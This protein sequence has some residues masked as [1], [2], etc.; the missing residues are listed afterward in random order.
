MENLQKNHYDLLQIERDANADTIK[1][2]F[3]KAALEHHPDK[4]GTHQMFQIIKEAYD[5]LSDPISK[6][7][8]DSDLSKPAFKKS[9]TKKYASKEKKEK[10]PDEEKR[11]TKTAP[12]PTAK[13]SRVEIP[14]NLNLLSIKELKLLLT[15]LGLKHDDCLKKLEMINRV[16]DYKN[17]NKKKRS[18]TNEAL[19]RAPIFSKQSRNSTSN[20]FTFKADLMGSE[21]QTKFGTNAES[22]KFYTVNK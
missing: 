3:R 1:K 10:K 9:G 17:K 18:S 2:S 13:A 14:D 15:S 16:R 7:N 19:P 5:I 6:I 21:K 11:S 20:A 22:V 12:E 4:G 8:Y